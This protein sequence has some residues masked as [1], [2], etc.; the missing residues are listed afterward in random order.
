MKKFTVVVR[1]TRRGEKEV[2]G[3][4]EEL[5]RYFN[6]TFEVGCSWNNKINRNPKTIKSF[7]KALQECFEEKEAQCFERS[8]VELKTESN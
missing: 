7:C 8:F 3:T 2:S 5:K 4:L 6:Y 1:H